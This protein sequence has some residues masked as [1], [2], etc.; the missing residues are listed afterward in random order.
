MDEACATVESSWARLCEALGDASDEL[1]LN[2][3]ASESA[4]E[5]AEMVLGRRLPAE[6]RAWLAIADGQ[7]VVDDSS[8]P[9]SILPNGNWFASLDRVRA[10]WQHERTYD[11]HSDPTVTVC[12]DDDRIRCIV[13]TAE[14]WTIAGNA[15][16]DGDNT[17]I[18]H[19][20]GPTGTFG[21]LISFYTECDL[22]VTC[23]GGL[24]DYFDRIATLVDEG[25]LVLGLE[26]ER[27][28]LL[29]AETGTPSWAWRIRGDKRPRGYGRQRR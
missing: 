10:H 27:R 28:M 19:L 16:F 1:Q 26:D 9:L 7:D 6:Y 2:D 5:A 12:Q 22:A 3:G 15:Y 11:E 21:Q 4:L 25:T 23:H 8:R 20:P 24:A 17:L 29:D 18:D 13:F 14:R